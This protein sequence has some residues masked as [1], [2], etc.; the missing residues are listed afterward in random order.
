VL[1]ELESFKVDHDQWWEAP[2]AHS[3]CLH[4]KVLTIGA[5]N[6]KEG[7]EEKSMRNVVN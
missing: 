3:F 4:A 5:V 2:D 1:R 7:Q 6:L